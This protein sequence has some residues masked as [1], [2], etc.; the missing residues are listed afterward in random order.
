MTLL[1]NCTCDYC[2]SKKIEEALS[3]KK[4]ENLQLTLSYAQDI[5]DAWPNMTLRTIRNMTERV[6]A[7]KEAL[8]LYKK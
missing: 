3:Q 5:V 6:N 2:A 8:E 7:L 1:Y 4:D